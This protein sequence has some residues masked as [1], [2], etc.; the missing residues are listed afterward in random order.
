MTDLRQEALTNTETANP[1]TPHSRM[2]LAA[3]LVTAVFVLSN[4]PTPLYIRW[5]AHLGFSSGMLTVIFAAYIAGLL[6]ALLGA[7]QISDQIG[8][9]K[10]VLPGLVVALIACVLF[11]TASSIP[12]LVIARFLTGLAVGVIVSAGMATVVDVGGPTR[13]Q[14]AALAAS[15]AMVFGAGMGPLL[16]GILAELLS[17]P[18]PIVFGI[19][20]VLLAVGVFVAATLP[21]PALTAGKTRLAQVRLRMPSVPSGNRSHVAFGVAVFGPGITATSFVLSLGPSVLSKQLGVTSPLIV[22]GIACVMFLTA[23]GVQFAVRGQ[24]IRR[25]FLMGS[26]ATI[27]AMVSL[28]TAINLSIPVLLMVSAILSGAGQGLGQLGGLTLIGVHVPANR[29][30]EANAV[31]NIGGYIPAG[32]LSVASGY[33]IDWSGI[34]TATAIF[35]AILIA[36]AA[37]AIVHVNLRLPRRVDV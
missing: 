35:A 20:F 6:V 1:T 4:S 19:E 11:A 25:I 17:N 30:A 32:L 8:R 10:V 15:V 5:Q 18:I 24:P 28:L 27:V 22:G 23:T 34:T 29:R 14:Q 2:L 21:V 3:G 36:A 12:M 16:A 37:A 31:L 26:G 13:K 9:K 7:G 33:L